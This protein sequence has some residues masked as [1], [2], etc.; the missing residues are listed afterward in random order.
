MLM[1]LWIAI[2]LGAGLLVSVVVGLAVAAV[3]GAIGREI[4][5]LYESETWTTLPPTRSARDVKEHARTEVESGD[6]LSS[7]RKMNVR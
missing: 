6:S 4:S 3:L 1:W 2:G 5:E 7:I